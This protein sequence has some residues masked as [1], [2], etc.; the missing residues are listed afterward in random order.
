MFST[1]TKMEQ[2]ENFHKN[3]PL[4]TNKSMVFKSHN[5]H[6]HFNQHGVT[7]IFARHL[8]EFTIFLKDSE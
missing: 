7:K 8:I 1:V 2:R 6:L 4:R 5:C 3:T